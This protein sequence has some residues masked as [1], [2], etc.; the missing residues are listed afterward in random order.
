MLNQQSGKMV[1]DGGNRGDPNLK[2][3]LREFDT[4]GLE[5]IQGAALLNR[6]DTKYIFRADQLMTILPHLTAAYRVLAINDVRLHAYETLYFDTDDLTLYTRHHNGA[7][8]RFKVRARKY[9]DT[10]L[11]FFE[12]K[13]RT[14]QRRTIKSRLPIADVVTHLD[15][16]LVAFSQAQAFNAAASLEPKLWNDY[17]RMTLVSIHRPERVTLDVGLS[18]TWGESSVELPGIVIAEVKQAHYSQDSAFIQQMRFMGI[19]PM[20]YSKYAAGVYSLYPGVKSNNFKPQMRHIHKLTQ[21]VS[22]NDYTHRTGSELPAQSGDRLYHRP[23]YL[24]SPAAG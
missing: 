2:A 23:L 19:R 5:D 16:Q 7:A 22:A 14:N 15:G 17:M 13:Q 4:I 3:V 18:Y 12:I 11:A 8:S 21:G 20:S 9:L 24:L 1:C 6:V 10:D